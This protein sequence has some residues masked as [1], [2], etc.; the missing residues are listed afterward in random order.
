MSCRFRSFCRRRDRAQSR[1]FTPEAYVLRS[2]ALSLVR[3]KDEDKSAR[4]VKIHRSL[5]NESDVGAALITDERKH[6][7]EWRRPSDARFTA[8]PPSPKPV[9][10]SLSGNQSSVLQESA[11]SVGEVFQNS[12]RESTVTFTVFSFAAPPDSRF[13]SWRRAVNM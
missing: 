13:R 9:G 4:W 12:M 3:S 11:A 2:L 6:T 1:R 8:R 7:G 5:M 10:L